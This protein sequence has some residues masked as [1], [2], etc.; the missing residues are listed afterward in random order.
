MF[1]TQWVGM[2]LDFRLKTMPSKL[3]NIQAKL[4]KKMWLFLKNNAKVLV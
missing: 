2:L 4:L 3:A 1:C